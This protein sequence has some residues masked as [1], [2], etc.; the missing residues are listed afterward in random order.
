MLYLEDYLEMIEHL[1]Q[2]LRDRF[3]EM[4][5]L[6]LAVQNNMDSL[7][8]K[9]HLFFKQCKRDEL[10]HES[11]D[12]EFHSLR[13]EYF[14]VMEDA[15]E[16]VAIATQIHELVERYL[17]RLDSELFKFK[18]ELE[19]DNNGI[20]EILE[21]RSLELDGN[22]TAATALLLSM[23][24]KENRYYGASSINSAAGI[25]T[26]T[27][28]I[29]TGPTNL[30][31]PSTP[32][33]GGVTG[34]ALTTSLAGSHLSSSQRHRKL[35]K[36]RET[37]CTVPVQEK[38]ANLNHSLPTVNAGAT[39]SAPSSAVSAA[40]AA[41]AASGLAVHPAHAAA[42]SNHVT[43]SIAATHLTLPVAVAGVA[44]GVGGVGV[45]GSA[46]SGLGNSSLVGNASVVRQLPTN[47]S[48]HAGHAGHA[49]HSAH[50][51]LNSSAVAVAA[52]LSSTGVAAA[53]SHGH[54]HSHSH[55]HGHGH[56]QTHGH[57]HGHGHGH[58]HGS[59]ASNNTTVTYNLQQLG[60]GT[61]ASSAIAAAASQA[62]VATQQMQ[63]GRRTASLKA[64]YEA[65][66]GAGTTTDFWSNAGQSS[67]QTGGATVGT[68]S[69]LVTAGGGGAAAGAAG[70]AA[71]HHHHQQQQQQQQQQLQQQQQQHHGSSSHH[72][73]HSSHGS[74]SSSHH[75]HHHHHQDKKQSK[76]K[77]SA[78]IATM[79]AAIAVQSALAGSSSGNSIASSSSSLSVDSVDM[80]SSA[81][82]A[83]AAAAAAGANMSGMGMP[84]GTQALSTATGGM[85]G[86]S[87][88]VTTTTMASNVGN[89]GAAIGLTP[90]TLVP[91][92]NLNIG[93]MG[94]VLEQPNEGEWSYDPNE[95]R[96]CTCNQVSYGDMVA[97]DNDACPF[98][99][100]HYPCVG[101]TQPPKGKW[102]CPK[103]TA[104]MRR[105][106]NRKN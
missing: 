85:S 94:I 27:G 65:I 54:G 7:D 19:A 84:H 41:A 4:R 42:A 61:A 13:A 95:P 49:G 3:T 68:A 87:H 104:T 17:R 30:G 26:S 89:V 25:I 44:G 33:G 24:Q 100:F 53:P 83:A 32:V 102:F 50:S 12:T 73:H 64:S 86:A 5:E 71:T 62:I 55:G 76:K 10:Q 34:G 101:I 66:H 21:R 103:C 70:A 106:G 81:A 14:K 98:E 38:R 23:N 75:H 28:S 80:L 40:A 1:P 78:S 35:E 63:Q 67:L 20:T 31:L 45:V 74:G 99:W 58:G 77:L 18:C 36:R 48:Q 59:H 60:G 15:D 51:V 88:V 47:L 69:T 91:G 39:A 6:D 9:S 92:S 105:R 52:A 2:E 46:S 43:N 16:K 11:M 72:S 22:S 8:K 90:T 37:I 97:C 82:A 79:P 56:G 57:S 96:Y 29:G 93:E